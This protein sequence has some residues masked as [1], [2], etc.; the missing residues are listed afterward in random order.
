M[1][2]ATQTTT[3]YLTLLLAITT[4]WL[5]FATHS[6]AK[7]TREA[8]ELQSRSY[9]SIDGIQIRTGSLITPGSDVSKGLIEVAVSISNPGQVLIYYEIEEFKASYKDETIDNPT[10]LTLRNVL[11]PNAKSQYFYPTILLKEQMV[12]GSGVVSLKIGFWSTLHTI[13]HVTAIIN[14]QL[15][16]IEPLNVDWRFSNGPIYS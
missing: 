14:Y 16:S 8:V 5:G 15:L 1:D 13:H 7:S 2:F 4:V 12:I 3:N 6:M 9:F 10:F 11:H